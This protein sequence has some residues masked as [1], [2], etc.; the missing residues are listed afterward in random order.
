M[1]E[2]LGEI[3]YTSTTE[4]VGQCVR[5]QPSPAY[6]AFIRAG[7]ENAC[8]GVVY[9]IETASIDPH[10]RPS[11]LGVPEDQLQQLY[12]QLAG[13]LRSEFQALLIGSLNEIRFQFGLPAIP[14]PLHAETRECGDEEVRRIG[15]DLGFLRLLYSSGKSS[16]EELL[17]SA[18]RRLLSAYS[19]ER[20]CA[21]RIGKAVSELFR[22]DY[23]SLRRIAARLEAGMNP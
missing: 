9:N 17:V 1:S 16:A 2:V 14:P 5:N 22:D 19:W 8:I 12:P 13:L 20:S 21:V 6:G 23:D 4:I 15:G 11:A 3:I 18:C 7:R 10:R